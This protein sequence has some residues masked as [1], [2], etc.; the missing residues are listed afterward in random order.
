MHVSWFPC[1]LTI[2]CIILQQHKS[3]VKKFQGKHE[4]SNLNFLIAE[5]NQTCL[6]ACSETAQHINTLAAS[7]VSA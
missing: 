6:Q 1:G 3:R 2:I 4:M 5:I 7:M